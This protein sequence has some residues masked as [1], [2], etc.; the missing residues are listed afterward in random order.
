MEHARQHFK[1]HQVERAEVFRIGTTNTREAI[2]A[3]PDV[4]RRITA[5]SGRTRGSGPPVPMKRC[6]AQIGR[7]IPPLH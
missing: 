6:L 2:A 3:V 7:N 1:A 4:H 5:G